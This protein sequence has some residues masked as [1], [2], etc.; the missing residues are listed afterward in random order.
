VET[1]I[2]KLVTGLCML[3]AVSPF[4][5]AQTIQP[6]HF[7]IEDAIIGGAPLAQWSD[8]LSRQAAEAERSVVSGVEAGRKESRLRR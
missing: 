3:I 8:A 2:H 1:T 4:A 7:F 6:L 5:G